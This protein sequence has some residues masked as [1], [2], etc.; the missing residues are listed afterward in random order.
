MTSEEVRGKLVDHDDRVK[1]NK[2][3]IRMLTSMDSPTVGGFVFFVVLF[4]NVVDTIYTQDQEE[5]A[6]RSFLSLGEK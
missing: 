2:A 5:Q 4:K 3:E 1:L 6:I